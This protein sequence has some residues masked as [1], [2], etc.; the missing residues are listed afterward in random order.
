MSQRRRSLACALLIVM[1]A[2]A[3]FMH[4]GM[5]INRFARLPR[6]EP[7]ETGRWSRMRW[8][9][10]ADRVYRVLTDQGFGEPHYYLLLAPRHVDQQS[11]S[12]WVL[13]D[14][15]PDGQLT[16]QSRALR[17]RSSGGGLAESGSVKPAETG[18]PPPPEDALKGA[19]VVRDLGDGFF[20][21]REAGS[22]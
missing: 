8:Q 5:Q 10:P 14:A 4:V 19:E 3:A 12:P 1:I 15:G 2:A 11:D 16:Q 13:L 6:Q 18:S 21:L 9:L 20:L 22:P 17:A 7:A